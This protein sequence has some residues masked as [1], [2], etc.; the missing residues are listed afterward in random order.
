MNVDAI[1]PRRTAQQ[2]SSP[3]LSWLLCHTSLA[4]RLN[5][6]SP[7][8]CSILRPVAAVLKEIYPFFRIKRFQRGVLD[9]HAVIL[10]RLL[11]F[12]KD[13]LVVLLTPRDS[14]GVVGRVWRSPRSHPVRH[15]LVP[16]AVAV[17]VVILHNVPQKVKK[18]LVLANDSLS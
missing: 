16:D 1:I 2:S 18:G 5:K 3:H 8:R 9:G 17:S 4:N 15:A 12:V 6:I 14:N 13:N 10:C 11:F 7:T